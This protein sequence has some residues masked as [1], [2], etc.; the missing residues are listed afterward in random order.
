[1]T[2]TFKTHYCFWT[3]KNDTLSYLILLFIFIYHHLLTSKLKIELK[4]NSQHHQNTPRR[5]RGVM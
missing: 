3:D 4:G 2:C 1:M 5:V